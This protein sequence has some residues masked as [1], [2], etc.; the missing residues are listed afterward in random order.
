MD[1]LK[2][3][4]ERTFITRPFNIG[5]VPVKIW[6]ELDKY[7]KEFYD[8]NRRNMIVDLMKKDESDFKYELLYSE[9]SALLVRI[10]SLEAKLAVPPVVDSARKFKTFGKVE[11]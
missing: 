6:E 1:E 3:R 10:E 4:L 9:I 7:C 2:E 8:D 11:K 5:Y